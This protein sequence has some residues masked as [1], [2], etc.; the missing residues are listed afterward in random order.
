MK[1]KSYGDPIRHFR[2]EDDLWNALGRIGEAIDRPASWLVRQA[3]A[4]F[5]ERYKDTPAR[6]AANAVKRIEQAAQ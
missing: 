4:E 5:V 6:A 2:I 3:I 1:N